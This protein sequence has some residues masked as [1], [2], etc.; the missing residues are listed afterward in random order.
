MHHDSVVYPPLESTHTVHHRIIFLSI[1]WHFRN[2][3]YNFSNKHI[4]VC[5]SDRQN[6]F[7]AAAKFLSHL[8]ALLSNIEGKTDRCFINRY[9]YTHS[10]THTHTHSQSSGFYNTLTKASKFKEFYLS[11]PTWS[12]LKINTESSA[13]ASRIKWIIKRARDPLYRFKLNNIYLNTR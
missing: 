11:I 1:L 4:N 12:K 9:I 6:C 2:K 8:A 7:L 10:G 3:I 13:S 5:P